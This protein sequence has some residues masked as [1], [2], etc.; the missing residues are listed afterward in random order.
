MLNKNNNCSCHTC[1]NLCIFA[2]HL[3]MVAG[4]AWA[5]VCACKGKFH[6]AA[7]KIKSGACECVDT[8]RDKIDDIM[9]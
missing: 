8:V 5:F 1:R 7:D 6:R 4:I 3:V 2:A 9:D